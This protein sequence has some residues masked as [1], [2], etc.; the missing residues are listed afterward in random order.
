MRLADCQDEEAR[1]FF[2]HLEDELLASILHAPLD[3]LLLQP[4]KYLFC[5]KVQIWLATTADRQRPKRP[6][7]RGLQSR[8]GSVAPASSS[9]R[10]ILEALC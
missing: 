5:V 2:A 9:F 10:T 3:T 4:M 8:N 1:Q 6:N 7:H